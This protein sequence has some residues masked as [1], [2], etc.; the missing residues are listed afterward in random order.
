MRPRLAS[1][2]E[3]VAD[4]YVAAL[5]VRSA[6]AD[7]RFP[8]AATLPDAQLRDHA[9]PQVAFI[10]TQL[11]TLGEMRGRAA[12]LLADGA[13]LQRVIAELH[14]AQRH[15]LGWSETDVVDEMPILRAEVERELEGTLPKASDAEAGVPAGATVDHGAVDQAAVDAAARYATDVARHVLEQMQQTALRSYRFA[16]AAA[17]P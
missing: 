11:M 7:G 8:G 12:E 10:A 5:R 3:S 2:A 4:R 1:A 17:T 13:Q 16:R 14:G 9:T 6:G 15:R